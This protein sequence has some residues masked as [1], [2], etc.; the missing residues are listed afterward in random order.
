MYTIYPGSVII[1]ST[2]LFAVLLIFIKEGVKSARA[3]IIGVIISNVLLSALFGITSLQE[4]V[5]RSSTNGYLEK[6][7]FI[8]DYSYFMVGTII[9]L[10]DFILMVILYQFLMSKIKSNYYFFILFIA[11]A[12]VLIFDA[13]AFNILLKYHAPDFETSLIGHIIGKLVAAFIF[14]IILYLYIKY[15]DTEDKTT[16]LLSDHNRGIYAILRYRKKY[17]DLKLEKAQVEK[18]LVSQLEATLNKISDGFMSFDTHWCFTY[19]NIKAGEFLGKKPKNLLGK[20]IWTEFPKSVGLPFYEAYQKADKTQTTQNLQ[21]Y[22][23]GIDKWYEHRIYP[24]SNGL[25]IY[26]TDITEQK[27]LN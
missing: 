21:E 9:L 25:S 4:I 22:H 20:H 19:I 3:L 17:K 12:S 1:F 26:F 18:K 10:I 27:K 2:V 7:V 6:P 24:S 11:L 15:I 23:E 16:G 8:L 5:L 14:S 13:F